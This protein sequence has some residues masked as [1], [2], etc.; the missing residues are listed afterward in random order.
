MPGINP[1]ELQKYLKDVR[2]PV[3]KAD[4]V[5]RAEEH[6]ATKDIRE[7]LE[8]LNVDEF[9]TPMEVSQAISKAR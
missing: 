3:S 4:L 5:R 8:H 6:G 2:Y 7:A 1:I 9:K